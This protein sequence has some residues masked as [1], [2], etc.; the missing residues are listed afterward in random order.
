MARYHPVAII[1]HWIMAAGFIGMLAA[2]L[3]MTYLDIPKALKFNLYQWHK[4]FGV[5]LFLTFFLRLVWRLYHKPPP[6]PAFM[7]NWERK[8]A[9][10]GHRLLYLF[11]F[12]VPFSGWLM[13]SSSIYGLPTI[14]FGWFEWPHIPG[15]AANQQVQE[16]ARLAH[17]ILTWTFGLLIIGHIGAIIKHRIVDKENLLIRMGWPR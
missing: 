14:V 1:F 15:V 8:A 13:V 12:L 17:W 3:A 10:L 4:S 6:L 5:L 2:G 9:E 7:P 16:L 11:M